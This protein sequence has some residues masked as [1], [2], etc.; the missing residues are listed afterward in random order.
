[1]RVSVKHT[2]RT[3]QKFDLLKLLSEFLSELRFVL[4]GMLFGLVVVELLS[5]RSMVAPELGGGIGAI[6]AYS[7]MKIL[8]L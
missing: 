1:M 3:G 6:V 2:E 4:A 8:R 7:V 5:I